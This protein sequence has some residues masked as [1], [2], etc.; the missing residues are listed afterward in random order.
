MQTSSRMLASGFLEFKLNYARIHHLGIGD[1][2]SSENFSVGG[3]LWRIY[4]FPR[5]DKVD[6][7]N[8]HLSIYL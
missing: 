8:E 7:H 2:V 1:A 5:G 4:C 6:G 3:Y